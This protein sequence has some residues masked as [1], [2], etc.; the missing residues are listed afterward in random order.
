ML[1]VTSLVM[2]SNNRLEALMGTITTD[3]L[4][5][6]IVERLNNILISSSAKCQPSQ[7]KQRMPSSF[8]WYKQ[9]KPLVKENK[10]IFWEWKHV[11]RPTGPSSSEFIAMKLAKAH[12]RQTQR[13]L[14]ASERRQ[15]YN[16][17]MAAKEGDKDMFYKL[18]SRQRKTP[19][20]GNASI[21][22]PDHIKGDSELQKWKDHFER[23]ATPKDL[24]EFDNEHKSTMAFRRLLLGSIPTDGPAPEITELETRKCISSLN[25]NKAPDIYGIT[26]EHLKRASPL[27]I[28]ML[29]ELSN[30]IMAEKVMPTDLKLGLA[31]PIPK[32]AN[33]QVDPD[34]FRRIT[35]TALVGKITEKHMVRLSDPILQLAQSPAQ[36]GFT[37]KVP[38]NIASML[39][40]ETIAHSKDTKQPVYLAFMDA[41]KAFDVVDHDCILNHLHDQGITG[42]L[43]HLYNSLYEDITSIIKWQGE[44]SD[45]LSEGQGIRQGAVSSTGSYKVQGNPC[46][47]RLQSHQDAFRIGSVQL[48]GIQVADDLVVQSPSPRGIQ[49]LVTEAQMHASRERFSFSQSKTK[50]MTIRPKK[51]E[52]TEE[53]HVKLYGTV[54]ESSVSEIHLGITRTA[55]G[56][57]TAT[58]SARVQSARRTSYGLMGAGLHEL[59]G[60][61]PEVG[62]H[63]YSIYVVPKLIYG[64]E[65]LILSKPDLNNLEMFHRNSL[66]HIQHL[67]KS[68]AVPAIYL[69]LGAPP[70]EALIHIRTLTFFATILR[71]EESIE[72]ELIERQLAMKSPD[73]HSWVWYVHKLLKRYNLPS[74]FSLLK[75]QPQKDRWRQ[76]VKAAVLGSWEKALKDEAA[77]KSTLNLVNL[78]ACSLSQAHPAWQLGATDTLT[79]TKATIKTKLLVQRY[80]L[81]YS[82]TSGTNYGYNC[83]LCKASPEPMAHFLLHCPALSCT[84]QPYL[85][86]LEGVVRAAGC[87]LPTEEAELVE[88]ILDPSHFVMSPLLNTIE[89]ISR[90]L[91]FALHHK[92]STSLG[93]TSR[94]VQRKQGNLLQKHSNN[95]NFY[96]LRSGSPR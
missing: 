35:I 54:I 52:A 75:D 65:A 72:Y 92:R 61:G 56:K 91:C 74:A 62:R 4:T 42:H 71:R 96:R 84:R 49:M 93:Y 14:A 8:K 55:D 47:H 27:I 50:S 80:P 94:Y 12:L 45:P 64:L 2:K 46:L 32:K 53:A 69:L 58:I 6:V 90:D 41:S 29:T 57:N 9:L 79:A 39:V 44:L 66:R 16:E 88:L 25:N 81:F 22:F 77:E 19:L 87:M 3:T 70:I 82:R 43:W 5:S 7:A 26:S 95:T 24:P 60:V 15:T 83:P 11:D 89:Q 18:I 13:Q 59:T 85:S 68:T 10:R 23:L 73:S 78:N 34:K 37:K 28:P 30:R 36:F 21:N 33:V 31:T 51:Q 17:I 20:S 40:T 1:F 48:G 38:C 63:I 76:M 86:K 67:P